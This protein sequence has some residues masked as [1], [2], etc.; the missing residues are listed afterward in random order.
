LPYNDDFSVI[1]GGFGPNSEIH[2]L[3]Y[4]TVNEDS[5]LWRNINLQ[6]RET[7]DSLFSVRVIAASRGRDLR[8]AQTNAR[9]ITYNIVQKDS[10]LLLPEF[11][12]IPVSQGFRDQ[13]VTIEILVPAGKSL[14]VSDELNRFKRNAPPKVVR[15]RIN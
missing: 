2:D 15:R 5:L 4:L 7:S 10:L 14:E 1:S 6:I 8:L 3:P 9:Q 11:L 13:S 12:S